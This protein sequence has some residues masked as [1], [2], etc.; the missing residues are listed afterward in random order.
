MVY[1][2]KLRGLF[3]EI[4]LN[5]EDLLLL[6]TFQ[7]KYLSDR[8]A[9]KEFA[10]L[11]REFPVVHR[12]LVSKYPPISSFLS[13]ILKENQA[14]EDR[15]LI[16]TNCQEALWEIADLIIY[17]K[18]P[19]RF[20][21]QAPIKW[22]LDEI[23]T[24]TSL[25]GKVVADV[26]AGSGRISFLVAPIAQSVYAVEPLASFRSYMKD[27][28]IKNSMD[29]L[30]VMDGTLDSI[31]LPGRF[32][33]ILITSNAIG[34]NLLEELK[35]IERV[36]K[37]GGHAIHLLQSNEKLASP[38]HETLTSPPWNYTCIHDGNEEKMK[39]RYFKSL[40]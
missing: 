22:D 18:S 3:P 16:E 6:E 25:E 5:W 28:A 14:L 7:I 37:P 26:G 17:N 24:I 15:E 8:V 36:V 27:K 2:Q 32:L 4:S 29:N 19:E 23:S 34:W 38:F 40:N 35:E 21:A 20:D 9:V 33:D 12:F 10:S 31:P 11:I 30:F 1:S 13:R 39:L